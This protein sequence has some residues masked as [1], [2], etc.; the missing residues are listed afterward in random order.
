M[1]R[2]ERHVP[3]SLLLRIQSAGPI[4][5]SREQGDTVP[6]IPVLLAPRRL[7]ERSATAWC[8]DQQCRKPALAERR[9]R[10]KQ[11]PVSASALRGQSSRLG[12]RRTMIRHLGP[13]ATPW[14]SHRESAQCRRPGLDPWVAKIPWRRERLPTP[15]FWP[16]KS[17]GQ[18]SL[19]GSSPR[20]RKELDTTERLNLRFRA[21]RVTGRTPSSLL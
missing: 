7:R 19:E 4:S 15:V 18:K 13:R 16:G 21:G 5:R 20:G 1:G 9:Q 6:S 14:L 11:L 8:L 3:H 10:T 17:H 12:R 2:G